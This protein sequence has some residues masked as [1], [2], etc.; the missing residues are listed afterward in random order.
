MSLP[1]ARSPEPPGSQR[2]SAGRLSHETVRGVDPEFRL[3]VS[4]R[5]NS[6]LV[7][8][9]GELDL[10]TAPELEA[11]LV[12]QSGRVVVDLRQVSFADATAL[13]ALMRVD[14]R[15][16]QNGMNVAFIA[17]HAVQRLIDAI[18]L[19]DPLTLIEPPA[20]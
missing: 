9:Q 14:E 2:G 15:S 10:A 13:H 3:V 6:T 20:L 5:G 1:S 16:R 4:A 12:E 17:G 11:T 19:S 7:V 8:P 18:G